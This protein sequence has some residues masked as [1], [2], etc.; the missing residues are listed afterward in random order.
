MDSKR[1]CILLKEFRCE[2]VRASILVSTAVVTGDS[3]ESV[4]RASSALDLWG[5]C[6]LERWSDLSKDSRPLN[7]GAG[8]T[9]A[10]E[11]LTARLALFPQQG[12]AFSRAGLNVDGKT[13][14]PEPHV[15]NVSMVQIGQR[16][17]DVP[18]H[19]FPGN[20]YLLQ[21]KVSFKLYVIIYIVKINQHLVKNY[22]HMKL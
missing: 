16:E 14:R 8:A 9:Q 11:H 3:G 18:T 5:E 21:F 4:G 19:H 15:Q 7:S 17:K 12:V 22:I 1:L 20:V 6:E 13:W 10:Q 2:E